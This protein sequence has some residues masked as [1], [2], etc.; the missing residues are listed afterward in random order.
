MKKYKTEIIFALIALLYIILIS[1]TPLPSI[2]CK[3]RLITGL[4]CPGCGGNSS[5]NAL[6]NLNLYQAFRFNILIYIVGPLL[7]VYL[8]LGYKKYKKLQRYLL[9][10][11]LIITILFGVLRNTEYFSWLAPTIVN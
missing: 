10:I 4:W 2:P 3:F 9:G 8:Y 6:M 7:L 1:Y 5:I 11:I